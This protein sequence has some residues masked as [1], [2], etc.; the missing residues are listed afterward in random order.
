MIFCN[1]DVLVRWDG[2]TGSIS[3]MPISNATITGV[4]KDGLTT[5]TTF[6][7]SPLVGT[8]GSYTAIIPIAI[9]STLIEGNEYAVELTAVDSTGTDFRRE[10][11]VAGY[12][13]FS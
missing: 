11:H 12:K 8:P 5:L 3:G 6:T 7:F 13:D 4:L 10:M 2:M 9:T 1:A